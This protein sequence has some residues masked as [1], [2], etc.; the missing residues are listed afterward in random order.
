M[1][2]DKSKID[3]E[4]YPLVDDLDFFASLLQALVNAYINEWNPK[5]EQDKIL[6]QETHDRTVDHNVG[7][8]SDQLSK[9]MELVEDSITYIEDAITELELLSDVD[10]VLKKSADELYRSVGPH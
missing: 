9:G 10:E 2:I 1:A 3:E 4:F 5:L 7:A 6:A 8:L